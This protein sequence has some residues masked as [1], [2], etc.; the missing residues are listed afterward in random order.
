[1]IERRFV[2]WASCKSHPQGRV[3]VRITQM[4]A[5]DA[6][7][8]DTR[9]QPHHARMRDRADRFWPWSV[10]LPAC[11]LVQLAHRRYCRPLVVWT[12]ADNGRFVRVAMSILIEQYPHLDVND[13][14]EA[15]FVW[16][17]AAADETVI[18]E[19]FHVSYRPSLGR[20]LLDNAMVLSMNAGL[21]GRI[22]LHAAPGGGP[23]LEAIYKACGLH[24]LPETEPLPDPIR[25]ANDGRFFYTDPPTAERLVTERDTDR[26]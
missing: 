26:S 21:G 12:R 6:W 5:N 7:W 13:P 8:W 23:A 18:R 17:I 15:T 9:L 20:V 19:H 24:Q 11:H 25:K 1:M 3:P 10:L 22:G 4:T 16:F 2:R 14:A